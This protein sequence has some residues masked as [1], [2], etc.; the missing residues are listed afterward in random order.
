MTQEQVIKLVERLS[1]LSIEAEWLEFKVNNDKP[2]L[3]GEY[4]S[5][6][7]NSATL[8]DRRCGYLVFGVADDS[9][10]LVGTEFNPSTARVGNENLDAWLARMITGTDFTIH[11]ASWNSKNFVVFKIDAA[12]GR[13][14][15][16]KNHAYI[17]IGSYKKSLSDYP[18]KERK[19]WQKSAATCFETTLATELV[20]SK[21]VLELLEWDSLFKLLNLPVPTSKTRVIQKLVEEKF[22]VDNIETPDKYYITNLGAI[23]LAKD[24]H[25]FNHL[26]RKA[27]RVIVYKGKNKL[28]TVKEQMGSRG[29]AVGFEGLINYINALIPSNEEIGKVFRKEVKLYPEIAIRELVANALIHQDFSITG[30]GPMIELYE[31]RI[32]ISNPGKPLI[33]PLRFIDYAPRS[34]NEKLAYFMRRANICEERGSGIDKVIDSTE[35][36]QLPAPNFIS[37]GS[38]MKVIVYAKKT[39]RQM[40]REDKIRACYQHCCLKYVSNDVMTNQTLRQRFNVEEKNYP[41]ISR[42]ITDTVNEKLIKSLEPRSKKYIPFWAE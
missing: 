16:F 2:D 36:Y 30:S 31:D 22:I 40:T 14:A 4:I 20:T 13:P 39:L 33:D 38:F 24:L 10:E 25:K 35:F 42:I 23:L 28:N 1:T 15:K 7:A 19:I 41:M 6:I 12:I 32:E 34:R 9:H 27:I 37:E 26:S 29:Y 5:A 18:D 21:E 8:C 17:R 3:I 11:S